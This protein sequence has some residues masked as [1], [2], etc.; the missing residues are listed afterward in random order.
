MTKLM[1]ILAAGALALAAS[2]LSLA[3]DENQG[4]QPPGTPKAQEPTG[5]PA[6]QSKQ[7]QDYLAALKKCDGLEDSAKQ[8]CV[9][10]A[11]QKHNRM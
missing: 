7:E 10:E 3:A 9:N 8:K 11:K 5:A 6:E 2:G 1:S 4:Q